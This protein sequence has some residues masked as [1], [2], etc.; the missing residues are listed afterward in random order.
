MSPKSEDVDPKAIL[1]AAKAEV[2]KLAPIVVKDDRLDLFA[3]IVSLLKTLSGLSGE[4]LN[5]MGNSMEFIPSEIGVGYLFDANKIAYNAVMNLV[6]LEEVLVAPHS[7]KLL[8]AMEKRQSD[9]EKLFIPKGVRDT[10]EAAERIMGS[11]SK[12]IVI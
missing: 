7:K 4:C 5:F 6:R 1:A 3:H 2:K 8:T 9:R 11:E 12:T 10:T